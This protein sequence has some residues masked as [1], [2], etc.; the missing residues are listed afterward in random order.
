MKHFIICFI[1]I[2]VFINL[3]DAQDKPVHTKYE[4]IHFDKESFKNADHLAPLNQD[5]TSS[6]WS[7]ATLSFIESE[8]ARLGKKPVKLAVMFPVYYA[9]VEK[10]KYFL[11]TKGESHFA[12]GDLFQTVFDIVQSHWRYIKD[13]HVQ[14]IHIITM[15]CM[16][17]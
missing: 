17:N 1:C 15:I 7:F 4:S 14:A 5:T 16:Q 9:F 6:C 13:R 8:M 10:A 2:F 3:A 11:E 12:P